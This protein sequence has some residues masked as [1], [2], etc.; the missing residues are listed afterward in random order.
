MNEC[1][2]VTTDWECVKLHLN[3]KCMWSNNIYHSCTAGLWN[4]SSRVRD[5]L[6]TSWEVLKYWNT[7]RICLV[8]HWHTHPH[9][10]MYI[11]CILQ[12]CLGEIGRQ[13]K[14]RQDG[15]KSY[16]ISRGTTGSCSCHYWHKLDSMRLSMCVCWSVCVGHSHIHW[17]FVHKVK[18]GSLYFTLTNRKSNMLF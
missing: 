2:S 3:R 5:D 7:E 1:V 10:I 18:T 4:G 11:E 15:R 12:Q 6:F 17:S 14:D 8:E 9:S 16:E 13:R